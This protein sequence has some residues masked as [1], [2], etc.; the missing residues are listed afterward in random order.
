MK[1]IKGMPI[2]NTGD[3]GDAMLWAGLM[4]IVGDTRPIEGIKQCQSADGRLWRSPARVHIDKKN[5]FSRDMSLGFILYFM[6]T[7]DHD[8]ANKWISYI[9]HTGYLF[10]PEESSDNRHVVTPSLWWAMSYAGMKVPLKWKLTRPLYRIMHKASL[11]FVPS[12]F[13]LHLWAV[14]LL[15]L[16]IHDGKRDIS[17]GKRL[18]KREPKNAFFA[19]LAGDDAE[20]GRILMDCIQDKAHSG[21]GNGHQWCWEREDDEKAWRDS[22]GW[23]FLFIQMLIHHVY[24]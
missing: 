3:D 19:W 16:N 8:M 14:S 23:D 17:L 18:F 7:K 24:I 21:Q 20:A 10:P 4:S 15:I 1:H 2:K 22:M 5:S 6:K 13:E 12:G 9:K 11:P